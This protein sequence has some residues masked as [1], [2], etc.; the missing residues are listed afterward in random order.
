M[1]APM[2]PTLFDRRIVMK[3]KLISLFALSLVLIPTFGFAKLN[4]VTT[5]QDLAALAQEVGGNL[6]SVESI[7]K[8]YMDPH[9]IEAK[10]SYLL[11]L[12]KADLFVEV[13]LELEVGW[14]PALL[15]TA[16]NSKIL[17]GAPGFLD[18]SSGCNILQKN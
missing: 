5:T 13:G 2:A 12:K 15:T 18:A 11:K 14:A 7:G 16:R 4:V 6:V 1:W 9:F 17:P 8:G 10:P 3:I